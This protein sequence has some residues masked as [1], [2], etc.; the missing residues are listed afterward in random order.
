MKFFELI[1][2]KNL[3]NISINDNIT[4]EFV[5]LIPKLDHLRSIKINDKG[6]VNTKEI[7][8]NEKLFEKALKSFFEL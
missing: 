1:D 7:E 3:I 8:Q 2:V 5:N 4:A 6:F